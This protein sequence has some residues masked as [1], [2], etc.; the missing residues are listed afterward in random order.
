M[1]GRTVEVEPL[2]PAKHTASLWDAVKGPENDDLWQYLF[3]GPY[4]DA[5]AFEHS[6]ARKSATADPLFFAIVDR[7]RNRA[8]GYASF[9]R[10]EPAH[11]VVE[12]GGILYTP[13]LQRTTGATEAMYLMARYVFE[14]LGYRRY[15]WKC[16]A[17]NAPSRAAAQRLGFL[18][19]GTFRQAEVHKGRSRDSAWF[20]IID[21]EW[22]A[23]RDAFTKWL[24]PENFDAQG[25]Q[26]T[27]LS[28]LTRR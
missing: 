26:K 3:D 25:R 5:A 24:S 10:I 11:K 20:S 2:E 7:A 6:I 16:N 8:V 18:Y 15:E 1:R 4:A 9:M 28:Q 14:E 17:L 27:A 12:V 21:K 22:P 13:L 19:E 23:L